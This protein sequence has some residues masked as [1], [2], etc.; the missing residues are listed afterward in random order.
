MCDICSLFSLLVVR[1]IVC[2]SYL[3]IFSSI[4]LKCYICS[5]FETTSDKINDI[6]SHL[7]KEHFV[8]KR[9]ELINCVVKDSGCEKK[10]QT[11]NGLKKHIKKCI[12]KLD[13]NKLSSQ[14]ENS[15]S[16]ASLEYSTTDVPTTCNTSSS[17][18]ICPEYETSL[19]ANLSGLLLQNLD[20][21][22]TETE[23]LRNAPIILNSSDSESVAPVINASMLANDF[24]KSVIQLGVNQKTMN[25]FYQIVETLLEQTKK[26]CNLNVDDS[27]A[28]SIERMLAIMDSVLNHITKFDTTYKRKKFFESQPNYVKPVE[29]G[30]GTHWEQ[31]RDRETRAVFPA[32]VQSTFTYMSIIQTLEYLFADDEFRKTYFDYNEKDKHKCQDN[33]YIDFCCG[34]KFKEN[35]LFQEHPNSLQL[36]L[37]VDGFEICDALKTKA[38]KHGQTGFYMA[39]RNLPTRFAYN[40]ENIHTVALINST[41]LK[42]KETDYTNVL[43]II[44]KEIRYL[45]SVGLQLPKKSV[46]KGTIMNVTFD[47]LGGNSV[48]GFTESSAATYFCRTCLSSKAETKEMTRDDPSKYRTTV[49]YEN[50]LAIIENSSKVCVKETKGIREYCILNDLQY[51]HILDNLNAD[52]MHDLCEGSLQTFAHHFITI[53]IKSKKLSETQLMNLI[54]FFDYGVLNRNRVPSELRIDKANLNQNASQMKCLIEHL[55]FILFEF[56]ICEDLKTPW[57]CLQNLLKVLQICYSSK[58]TENNLIDLQNYIDSYL[59][60]RMEC[61][62]CKN[63]PKDHFMTHYP[64]II[65]SVGPL[66]HMSTLR[67]E[68][69]HKN[70]TNN[71]KKTN[72]FRNI[73]RTLSNRCQEEAY[74]KDK[75]IDVINCAAK[76]KIDRNIVEKYGNMLNIFSKNDNIFQIKW[77]KIN[78]DYFE[79][80]LMLKFEQNYHEIKHI[81]CYENDFYF[82]CSSYEFN[83]FDE[84]FCSVNISETSPEMT[85]LI[86]HSDLVVTKSYEKK[87]VDGNVFL[88]A[89][90]LDILLDYD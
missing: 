43:E 29:Y 37:F 56:K 26:L 70:F 61:F 40:S 90:S 34:Q 31:R 49:D 80:R 5:S 89:N 57:K 87:M 14:S 20:Y 52:I 18:I 6:L 27:H 82:I 74:L 16:C 75:Y 17:E 63:K 30:I 23:T 81:L 9:H 38:N 77:L 44:V 71:A 69:F 68:M 66:V 35:K 53:L 12:S 86:K 19:S 46:L 55:P 45:E 64:H 42:K 25:Q 36:Q 62:D 73:N 22:N 15:Q 76:K 84:F 7:K 28:N 79:N 88:I 1:F 24:M 48:L 10:F 78:S 11:C 4:M 54:S 60:Q 33:I 51:F 3:C 50:A 21:S 8:G 65:R 67:F 47:N 13:S 32:H 59:R 72:N 58:I 2:T 83:Y 39:I 85:S 41:D